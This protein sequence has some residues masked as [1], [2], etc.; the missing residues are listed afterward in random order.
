MS[1]ITDI[2]EFDLRKVYGTDHLY[3]KDFYKDMEYQYPNINTYI[4]ELLEYVK[5]HPNDK[6]LVFTKM[7]DLN[8]KYSITPKYSTIIYILKRMFSMYLIPYQL[9]NQVMEIL[10]SKTCRSQSGILQVAIMTGPG[11]FSCLMDCYFCPKQEGFARSYIKEE[12]SVRR[13]ADEGFDAAK[14]IWNRLTSYSVNGHDIDKLEIII[15]GGTWSNYPVEYQQEFMRDIY[16]AANSWFNR[17]EERY[18]LEKE[19]TINETALVKIIGI[20]TETR[21]DFITKDEV[22]RFIS[23]GVTRV[24]LGVQTTNDRVLK[25]INRQCYT[26]DVVAALELLYNYGFKVLIHIMPNLPG[27][28]PEID[29]NTFDDLIYRPELIADEWKIYPTSVTTTSKKDN[30]EVYT[31]IEKWYRE[32]K[33]VPYSQEELM[34]VLLYAKPNVPKHIRIARLFRDIP[35]QNI[36]GGAKVPHLRQVIH[37]RLEEDGLYCS[38]VRCRE[39][40]N[41]KFSPE[42]IYYDSEQYDTKNGINYYITAN[43]NP[44]C[45]KN[46][47]KQT[48]VGHL[49]LFIPIKPI[50]QLKVLTD[51]TIVREV[52]VYGKMLP[53]YN[54]SNLSNSQGRGI[55]SK[56]LQIAEELTSKHGYNKVAIISGVGVRD[57]YRKNGYILYENYMTKTMR[58]MPFK[59]PYYLDIILSVLVF[60]GCCVCAYYLKFN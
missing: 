6:R 3:I 24:Q 27:S 19:K 7:R 34:E 42:D 37:Q 9:F 43:L 15:L 8:K 55:G 46:P 48:L 10:K 59:V 23:Y 56:M 47:V 52:H 51:S 39:V 30:T 53:T 14:Q 13:A 57:F 16:Y 38:C 40:K 45:S 44:I 18:T 49:R 54:K 35:V 58:K 17:R 36:I 1:N 25:K 5:E 29:K 60:I 11:E 31:V 50:N 41:R 21:P 12:P 4:L 28:T 2:E 20:T 32:G 33:Y 22:M 26:K